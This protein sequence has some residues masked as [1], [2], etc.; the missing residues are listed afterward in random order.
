M[1]SKDDMGQEPF[2]LISE[3]VCKRII[4]GI[5]TGAQ[6]TRIL[7]GMQLVRTV[8]MRLQMG[9]RSLPVLAIHVTL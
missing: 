3:G 4:M 7:I 1:T 2:K 8:F 5:L 9:T 6:K